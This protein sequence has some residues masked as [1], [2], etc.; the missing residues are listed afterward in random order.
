MKS[1]QDKLCDGLTL[2]GLVCVIFGGIYVLIPQ[3]QTDTVKQTNVSSA[4]IPT[5]PSKNTATSTDSLKEILKGEGKPSTVAAVVPVDSLQKN[6]VKNQQMVYTTKDTLIHQ[7]NDTILKSKSFPKKN[8]TSVK[9][10]IVT[11]SEPQ[12]QIEKSAVQKGSNITP[13]SIG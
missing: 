6:S 13:D 10:S 9:D 12:I 5:A 1:F 2:L 11:D 3:D 7:P 8:D 4:K